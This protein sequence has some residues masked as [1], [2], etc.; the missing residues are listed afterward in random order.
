MRVGREA[1]SSSEW[2][3]VP[4]S[5]DTVVLQLKVLYQGMGRAL[6]ECEQ[7]V[8]RVQTGQR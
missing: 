5:Q 8:V 4:Q 1:E 7:S 3:G 6:I 2:E